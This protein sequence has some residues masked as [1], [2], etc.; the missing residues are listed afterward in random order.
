M[1]KRGW[2]GKA[3]DGRRLVCLADTEER[4]PAGE[5]AAE[6]VGFGPDESDRRTGPCLRERVEGDR[7][8][9]AEFRIA[10][11]RR[12]VA[13]EYEGQAV[14]GDLDGA[15]HEGGSNRVRADLW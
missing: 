1:R 5:C 2:R 3:W 10:A 12:S 14:A 8:D 11:Y 4:L 13:H 6:C 7:V 9:R 15:I